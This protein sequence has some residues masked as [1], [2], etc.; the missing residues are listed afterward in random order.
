MKNKLF[1]QLGDKMKGNRLILFLVAAIGFAGF[2]TYETIKSINTQLQNQRLQKV[3]ETP[4]PA[5]TEEV[6]DVQQE[7]DN[8]PLPASPSVVQKQPQADV[9][10]QPEQ[11][12]VEETAAQQ[13]VLPVNGK[14]FF[15]F[16]GD[17]LVYNRTL[18]DWRTHNGVDISAP[19]NDPVKAGAKGTVKAVYE[20]GMLG[21]VVEID[22]DGFTARYCGLNSSTFVKEGDSVTQGQSIGSVGETPLEVAEES[23][24]HL[25]II[26]DGKTI[27]PDKILK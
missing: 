2:Y 11:Q 1:G 3:E 12:P 5:P 10:A 13:F 6:Q 8:I 15:A 20:D 22:H 23:H 19:P 7:Q 17:E 14:I 24:I 25:E 16:S 4:S 27:N 21:T 9:Q 26:K 18:E